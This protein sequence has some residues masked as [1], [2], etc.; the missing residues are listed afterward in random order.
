MVQVISA[1]VA[2]IAAIVATA[3]VFVMRSTA[4]TELLR[5]V[6]HNLYDEQMRDARRIVYGLRERAV[7]SWSAEERRAVELV[8]AQYSRLGFLIKDGHLRRRNL[9]DTF[10]PRVIRAWAIIEPYVEQDREKAPTTPPQWIYF[11]WLAQEAHRQARQ[12]FRRKPWWARRSWLRLIR[13]SAVIKMAALDA[14]RL[15]GSGGS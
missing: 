1:W 9:I 3:Q 13:R 2:V 4:Q 14:R 8:G 11:E 15:D 12:R 10:G 7:E 5:Q 6:L